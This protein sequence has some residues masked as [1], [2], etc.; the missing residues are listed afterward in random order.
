MIY[1]AAVMTIV[2]V[3]GMP[4]EA[5]RHLHVWDV[6]PDDYPEHENIANMPCNPSIDD[7]PRHK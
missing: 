6:K 7:Q 5:A 1:N 3:E 2:I 4:C